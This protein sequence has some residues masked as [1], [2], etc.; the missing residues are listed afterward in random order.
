MKAGFFV[1]EKNAMVEVESVDFSRSE[2]AIA[3]AQMRALWATGKHR[4]PSACWCMWDD[5]NFS[6]F[7]LDQGFP[8][9]QVMNA[10]KAAAF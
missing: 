8:P 6:F 2:G 4:L 10:A 7:Y 5:D 9:E 1:P 3:C